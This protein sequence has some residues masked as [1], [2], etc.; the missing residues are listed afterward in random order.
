MNKQVLLLVLFVSITLSVSG[1]VTVGHDSAP[2]TGALLEIKNKNAGSTISS[3]D[4]D[5]N[6]TSDQGGLGLPRVKLESKT[7]LSPFV[8]GSIS[9]S[10]KYKRAGIMVYNLT[11]SAD[12]GLTKGTYTWNGERWRRIGQKFFYMPSFNLD[13]STV[14]AN[15]TI[16]LYEIYKKQ[17]TKANN[18]EFVSSNTSLS[19]VPGLYASNE[20]DYVVT[21]Y[22]GKGTVIT[23]KSISSTGIMTYDVHSSTAPAD[24]YINIVLVVKD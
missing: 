7:S 3:V 4:A 19:A 24:S 22:T 18:T 9:N 23:I 16:N 12:E 10:E 1:Q 17:F 13:I 15:K 6:V 8:T 11:E 20:L 5:N 14:G 21:G 2:I